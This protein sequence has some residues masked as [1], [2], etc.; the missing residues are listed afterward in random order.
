MCQA[1]FFSSSRSQMLSLRIRMSKSSTTPNK[2]T[3]RTEEQQ[4]VMTMC[5]SNAYIRS[6]I[7]QC[8]CGSQ[9]TRSKSTSQTAAFWFSIT[10]SHLNSK[11]ANLSR[12][13]YTATRPLRR[14]KTYSSVLNPLIQKHCV[15]LRLWPFSTSNTRKSPWSTT[16][17]VRPEQMILSTTI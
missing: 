17:G 15:T 1:T 10:S 8:S 3:K 9:M 4:V 7:K 12:R 6:K 16:T 13:K 14:P 2:C 5:L 11:A